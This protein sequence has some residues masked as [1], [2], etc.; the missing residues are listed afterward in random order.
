MDGNQREKKTWKRG[1]EIRPS[2]CVCC[3]SNCVLN[4]VTFGLLCFGAGVYFSHPWA[5]FLL[6]IEEGGSCFLAFPS[7]I[8]PY[9]LLLQ[10]QNE[11]SEFSAPCLTRWAPGTD[12]PASIHTL[13][14]LCGNSVTQLFSRLLAS[15]FPHPPGPLGD[16][17]VRKGQR[18][19]FVPWEAEPLSQTDSKSL[20]LQSS[21]RGH[22]TV[23]HQVR[24]CEDL[25]SNRF[26][27]GVRSQPSA[28]A[29]VRA[30]GE[31]RRGAAAGRV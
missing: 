23:S 20:L 15:H 19:R 7:Q 26:G 8:Y 11:P 4:A 21:P 3:G 9:K 25:I 16:F 31:G 14:V 17:K 5:D 6:L 1:S 28:A 22:L 24:I 12:V 18:L 30:N 27:H 29:V 13:A 10:D 2:A